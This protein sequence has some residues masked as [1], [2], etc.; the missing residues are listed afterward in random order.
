M[1]KEELLK[2]LD[3][4]FTFTKEYIHD[5]FTGI[6]KAVKE[7]PETEDVVQHIGFKFEEVSEES[8]Q[9]MKERLAC[10]N[11]QEEE[12]PD[13]FSKFHERIVSKEFPSGGFYSE[14]PFNDNSKCI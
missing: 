6:A 9:Q 5:T 8:K 2:L 7:L 13:L 10:C 1:N 12:P 11:T 14:H 3:N 4:H